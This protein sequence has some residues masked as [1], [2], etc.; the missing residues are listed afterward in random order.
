MFAR[1]RTAQ[2]I[3]DALL[4]KYSLFVVPGTYSTSASLHH[5]AEMDR[6]G[7]VVDHT[8]VHQVATELRPPTPPAS[9]NM[10]CEPCSMFNLSAYLVVA[11]RRRRVPAFHVEQIGPPPSCPRILV[12]A[13][14][15]NVKAALNESSRLRP[16]V[17]GIHASLQH[18]VWQNLPSVRDVIRLTEPDVG[19][20]LR[21]IP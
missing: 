1:I 8:H 21:L 12:L 16:L 17:P 2:P 9:K 4:K 13:R 6:H 7:S 18:R 11:P 15:G 3:C 14:V 5:A 10:R 19:I 20:T